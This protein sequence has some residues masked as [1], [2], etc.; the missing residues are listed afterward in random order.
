MLLRVSFS[1]PLVAGESSPIM[2]TGQSLHLN[3][4]DAHADH[5]LHSILYGS[6]S[7][8]R[9][10]SRRMLRTS[11][12]KMDAV[13]P[14]ATPAQLQ[15]FLSEW[16]THPSGYHLPR[17]AWVQLNRLRTGVGRFA[18]TMCSWGLRTSDQCVCGLPQTAQ[19]VMYC[20]AVGPPCPLT[21]IDNPTLLPYLSQC[22]F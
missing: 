1:R 2:S 6:H 20:V 4:R 18:A 8:A 13:Q 7:P 9:L 17:R 16:S 15:P 22:T 5:V 3:D 21:D 10:P 12:E 11:M 14:P 19:H